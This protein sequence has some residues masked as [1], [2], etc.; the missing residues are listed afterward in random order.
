M[1][2][3][4]VFYF[5]TKYWNTG[6]PLRNTARRA[7]SRAGASKLYISVSLHVRRI[8]IQ[9]PTRNSSP[10]TQ[11]SP[12]QLC[13]FPLLLDARSFLIDRASLLFVGILLHSLL[14]VKTRQHGLFSLHTLICFLRRFLAKIVSGQNRKSKR[15]KFSTGYKWYK[16]STVKS[17]VKYLY[18]VVSLDLVQISIAGTKSWVNLHYD[19]PSAL[20]CGNDFR[21]G[22]DFN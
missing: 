11:R 21:P 18:Q 13:L 10:H 16:I 7:C 4:F 15:G 2:S 22:N 9:L 6:I 14:L 17:W 3:V 19:E 8:K 1:H 20:P 5:N 12:F